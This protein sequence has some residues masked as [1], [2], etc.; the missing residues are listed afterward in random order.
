MEEKMAT[1]S[2]QQ[3]FQNLVG[4]NPQLIRQLKNLLLDEECFGQNGDNLKPGKVN[5]GKTLNQRLI[6]LVGSENPTLVNQLSQLIQNQVQ[7]VLEKK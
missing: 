1:V 3:Q 6:E 4:D 5:S 7:K 2:M